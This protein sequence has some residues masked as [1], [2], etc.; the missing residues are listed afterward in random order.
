MN[1][2]P[3]KIENDLE[4][5]NIKEG[6]DFIFVQ[7]PELSLIGTKE[8]YSDYLD[9]IFP[10]SKVVTIGNKGVSENFIEEDKPSFYTFD[11]DAAKHYSSLREGTKVISAVFNFK[12]PLIVDAERPSPIPII[13]PDGNVLGTF[14]DKDINEKIQTAGYDGLILNRKFS[15]PLDGWEVLSFNSD[16][17][18]ILGTQ[19][20]L[21]KFKE[22]VG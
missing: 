12:N 6:V 22:F 21:K 10:E 7:N 16:S 15:T 5:P 20:D 17:R 9:S 3:P 4:K 14:V 19:E 13:E 2:R 11:L 1:E 18:H 8:Q